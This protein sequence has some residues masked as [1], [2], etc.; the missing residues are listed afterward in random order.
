MERTN[1]SL[2]A[3]LEMPLA[4][5]QSMALARSAAPL[6]SLHAANAF[7]SKIES[8]E[9]GIVYIDCIR[10]TLQSI[11]GAPDFSRNSFTSAAEMLESDLHAG[12]F[13]SRDARR[14]IEQSIA[15]RRVSRHHIG[16]LPVLVQSRGARL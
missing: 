7:Y 6:S 1:L 12:A 15:Q 11:I 2:D 10:L 9:G 16:S 13:K 4:R 3:A 8:N 14:F 5:S